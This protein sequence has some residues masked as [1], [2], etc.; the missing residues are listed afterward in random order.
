M[1]ALAFFVSFVAITMGITV[2][3]SRR[4]RSAAD[5]YAAGRRI[6][7]WQ[8]GI[9]VA[10]DYMSAASFLG[11]AGII[12]TAGY[13]GFMY[14]VGWLVAYLTVLLI[15]AE[16]LRN[17][18]KYTLADVL[19][20]RLK[21][22]P[23]R[24]A[25][26]LSTLTVS[27]FYMIAQMVGA[28]SLINL[29]LKLEYWQAVTI[30]GVVMLV[31]V[32]FGG[33]TATTWVQIIKAILLILGTIA[34]TILVLAQFNFDMGRLFT[35]ATQVRKTKLV[36]AAAKDTNVVMINA[37]IPS[38]KDPNF[39]DDPSKVT[40]GMLYIGDGTGA[41]AGSNGEQISI[42]TGPT[43]VV[44][45]VNITLD[46]PLA[47]DF[48]KGALAVA[49]SD[50]TKLVT[51]AKASDTTVV[52]SGT[53]VPKAGSSFYIGNGISD[54]AIG[55]SDLKIVSAVAIKDDKGVVTGSTVTLDK[56][57]TNDYAKDT[58][59]GVPTKL[60]FDA[61]AGSTI[62]KIS[63][64]VAPKSKA[65]FYIGDG[66]GDGANGQKGIK[67]VSTD[68]GFAV[69]LDKPLSRDYAKSTMA[70]IP[71]DFMKPGGR[72]NSTNAVA[73]VP[74]VPATK[75]TPEVPAVPAKGKGW[76]ALDL[77]SLGLALI[78]GTAGLPH[79]LIRFF[80]V[81]DAVEARK[82]VI[83]AM[84]IIGGFYIMTTFL[85]YGA[86]TLIGV[87]NI[88]IVD[89][90]GKFTTNSNMAAVVLADKIGGEVFFAFVASVA[91]ATILAVVAGLTIT[92]ST[93]FAH[94]VWLNIV[95]SG[96][97]DEKEQLIVARITAFVVGAISITLAILMPGA[98]T[99]AL[100]ALAFAVAASSNLPVI[101]LTLFWKRFTTAGAVGGLLGGLLS[102]VGLI[103]ISYNGPMGYDAPFQLENPG[104]IS[105]PMGF[106]CAA[107]CTL[108]SKPEATSEVKY[109][110]MYFR[111][112]TGVGA[113]KA[114]VH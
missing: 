90:T 98:N 50:L 3:A 53:V 103:L 107:V 109:A 12:G 24:A 29:L 34:L 48:T 85:G 104:I 10:G 21:Q 4:N 6:K 86:A 101:V 52:V 111:S 47:K 106:I 72:Y 46:Q 74:A 14:S 80:T 18:G 55:Q 95:K 88:G 76:G 30:V 66:I 58:I 23:V 9:A 60:L 11:I 41:T 89:S 15:V 87:A 75:D 42:T 45:G 32:V 105:I 59:A 94:D 35:E 7:G 37:T 82:S 5:F 56:P 16:P 33:M 69:S 99:A 28:G 79:I 73:A 40:W 43:G 13:D 44:P 68:V 31:Y 36:A 83:W 78:F 65:D 91:F 96:H 112:E 71:N 100:V 27:G 38:K 61:K 81:P 67:V 19:A 77:I 108:L 8:N 70:G 102:S 97:E 51:E 110:E 93:A 25:A 49:P 92:A 114:S 1:T 62:V 63:G 54:G 20:Y 57:L 26:A 84:V 39:P 2:W 22:K 64:A 17:L 113:E